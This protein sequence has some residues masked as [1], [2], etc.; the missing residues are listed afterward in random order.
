M[1]GS[2]ALTPHLRR[3]GSMRTI[4]S[5]VAILFAT[6]LPDSGQPVDSHLCLV[7]G[8]LGGVDA[9]LNVLLFFPLGVGLALSGIA[10]NRAVLTAFILSATIETTQLFF[11]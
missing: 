10:G 7:C 4:G 9:V 5:V 3:I 2:V 11:I 8:T 6:L 1:R